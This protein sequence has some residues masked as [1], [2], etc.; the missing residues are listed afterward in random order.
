MK[1]CPEPWRGTVCYNCGRRGMTM[2]TCDRC[3][4]AHRA[5]L[6]EKKEERLV[7]SRAV[8]PPA[9]SSATAPPPRPMEIGEEK[10][11][12]QR[13]THRSKHKS[14]APSVQPA[15]TPSGATAAAAPTSSATASEPGPNPSGSAGEVGSSTGM[16]QA[17]I[18]ELLGGL[19][20]PLRDEVHLAWRGMGC[21]SS[22]PLAEPQSGEKSD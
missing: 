5:Y 6:T 19:P 18:D 22:A 8:D 10:K 13:K 9:V 2:R 15:P 17:V 4:L 1:H 7:R 21:C 3:G 14:K 20:A 12:P 16:R 11:G